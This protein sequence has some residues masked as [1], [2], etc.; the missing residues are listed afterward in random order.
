MVFSPKG[1]L[2]RRPLE[3]SMHTVQLFGHQG[4]LSTHC[5]SQLWDVMYLPSATQ[6]CLPMW[7]CIF[8]PHGGMV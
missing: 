4:S 7:C 1:D 8:P 3:H 6:R 5:F 2:L